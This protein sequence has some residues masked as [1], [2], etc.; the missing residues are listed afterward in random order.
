MFAKPLLMKPFD[1]FSMNRNRVAVIDPWNLSKDPE[2]D[3]GY[4]AFECVF[5]A[6]FAHI[7]KGFDIRPLLYLIRAPFV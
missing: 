1:P 6:S 2:S 5:W 3:F 7:I 4:G